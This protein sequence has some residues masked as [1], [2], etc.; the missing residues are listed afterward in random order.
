MILSQAMSAQKPG[1]SPRTVQGVQYFSHFPRQRLKPYGEIKEPTADSVMVEK[2]SCLNCEYGICPSVALSEMADTVTSNLQTLRENLRSL[3]ET[4]IITE[5]DKMNEITKMFN[6]HSKEPVTPSDVHNLLRYCIDDE[7]DGESDAIFDKMEHVGMLMYVIGSHQK[8][9]RSLVRNA[10]EYSRKCDNLSVRHEFK[11]NPTLKTLKNWWVSDT[12]T[13]KTQATVLTPTARKNLLADL[14]SESESDHAS[15]QSKRQKP[16]KQI[17]QE[18]LSSPFST[19]S[20]EEPPPPPKKASKKRKTPLLELSEEDL[21]GPLAPSDVAHYSSSEPPQATDTGA[22]RKSK[23][24]KPK[25][26][27]ISYLELSHICCV[28]VVV[29]TLF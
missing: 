7:T 14:G 10:P 15:K 29:R 2:A 3:D 18:A 6:T 17:Q 11:N 25:T 4:K 13:V 23:K 16:K 22:K 9:L 1:Y 8:Q 12:A 28:L 20:D 21:G 26:N 5:M 19:T 24:K 27:Q